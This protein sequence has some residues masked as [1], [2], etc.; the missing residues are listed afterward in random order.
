MKKM[1]A[2]LV[3]MLALAGMG[4]AAPIIGL[5]DRATGRGVPDADLRYLKVGSTNT[6]GVFSNLTV[7]TGMNLFGVAV[8][9]C[10][11]NLVLYADGTQPMTGTGNGGGYGWTNLGTCL[12]SGS[13]TVDLGSLALPWRDIFL[14]SN[15]VYLAGVKALSATNVTVGRFARKSYE[16]TAT[17]SGANTTI[18]VNVPA[19]AKL[20]GVQLRVDTAVTSGDGGT[21]WDAAF[22]GGSSTA[23]ATGKAFTMNTKVVFP[24]TGEIVGSEA[25]ILIDCNG[26]FTFSGGVIRAIVYYEE[27]AAMDDLP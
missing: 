20:I 18:Q 17:L 2:L 24:M 14:G 23:V 19:Q 22:S 25:D 27:I 15:S 16:A 9:N 5:T 13:N 6:L 4:L 26:A 12:P 8:T 3:S 7:T 21:S 10:D 11:T 1:F